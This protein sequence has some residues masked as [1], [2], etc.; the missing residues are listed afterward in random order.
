M[1]TIQLEVS[2]KN[3]IEAVE[4]LEDDEFDNFAKEFLHVRA[5]RYAPVLSRQET[6]LFQRINHWLTPEEQQQLVELKQKLED[7]TLTESELEKLLRLNEKAEAINVQR[8]EALAQL[9][10]LRQITLSE[11][12]Q[13][14]GLETSANA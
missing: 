8:F 3:L 6:E 10:D 1:A 9:A 2:P 13:S 11:L 14:L 7:E 5:R 4:Q 12:M